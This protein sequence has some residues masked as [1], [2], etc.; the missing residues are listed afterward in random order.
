[1]KRVASV[2]GIKPE[3]LAEYR[4]LHA[5]AWPQVLA[6]LKDAGISNYTIF[7]REPENLLFSYFEVADDWVQKGRGAETSSET[8]RWLEL[9]GPMQAPLPT[10]ESHEWWADTVEVFHLD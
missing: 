2:I 4:E 1:M 5:N 3:R 7:L 9:C 8:R 6:D 10:R